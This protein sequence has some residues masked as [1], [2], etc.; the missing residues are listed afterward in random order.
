MTRD[1]L[2]FTSVFPSAKAGRKAGTDRFEEHGGA[3]MGPEQASANKRNS[4][5]RAGDE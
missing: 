2:A 4:D 5:Q 1:L 3:V